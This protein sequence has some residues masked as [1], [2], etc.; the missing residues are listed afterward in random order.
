MASGYDIGFADTAG[1]SNA[2]P[3]VT[4]FG[5]KNNGVTIIGAVALVVLV[6]WLLLRK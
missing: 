4:T 1:A 2:S 6:V 5:S 3:F